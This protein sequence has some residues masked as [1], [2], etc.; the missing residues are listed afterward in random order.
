MNPPT[1][2]LCPACGAEYHSGVQ[3]CSDC[4]V[5]LQERLAGTLS[6]PEKE[7]KSTSVSNRYRSFASIRIEDRQGDP[8]ADLARSSDLQRGLKFW[9]TMFAVN[10]P[11]TLWMGPK[12]ASISFLIVA[13]VSHLLIPMVLT[14]LIWGLMAVPR[15]FQKRDA[16]DFPLVAYAVLY[17]VANALI[18]IG[19]LSQ[20]TDF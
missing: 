1:T 2:A 7:G 20:P 12:S 9:L 18:L 3:R 5:P 17:C 8:V 4:D 16:P 13:Y 6:T 10:V 19:Q 11:V 15:W 14:L